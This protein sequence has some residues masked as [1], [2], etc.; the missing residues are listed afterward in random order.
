MQLVNFHYFY[1]L[2]RSLQDL[3]R[4]QPN[5]TIIENFGSLYFCENSL[6]EFLANDLLPPQAC[7][8]KCEALANILTSH[9]QSAA[10]ETPRT[11]PLTAW[12][13]TSIQNALRDFETVLESEYRIKPV[14]APSK[15]GLYSLEQLV[16]R[17]FEM[18]PESVHE[19]MP[20]M[21]DDL[22]DAGR[23]I[24]FEGPTAAAFHLFRA[25]EAGVK[26]YIVSIRDTAITDAERRFGL[27]GYKRILEELGV[28]I[29]VTAALDQLIKLHR[30]PTIHPDVRVSNEEVLATLGMVDSFIRIVAIDMQRRK[31]TPEKSLDEFLPRIKEIQENAH[32][33]TNTDA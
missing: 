28:D 14:F 19:L 25:T 17:G 8:E 26:A 12:E 31:E 1:N 10:S 32:E 24:A 6:R 29:R 33:E 30:N 5:T 21:K 15:K 23:C 20:E 16:F 22:R 13:V 18:V 7:R 9:L 2:S 11:D 3:N 4:I 27:G